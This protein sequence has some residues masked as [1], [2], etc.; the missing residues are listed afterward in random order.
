MYDDSK[1]PDVVIPSTELSSN[2]PVLSS[3]LDVS[4]QVN[5]LGSTPRPTKKGN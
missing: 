5:R 1:E 2:E 4:D 3:I